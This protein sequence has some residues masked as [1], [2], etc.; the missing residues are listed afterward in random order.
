MSTLRTSIAIVC[1]V[2]SIASVCGAQTVD[3]ER[4]N[5]LMA[6]AGIALAGEDHATAVELFRELLEYYPV[7]AG[8]NYNLGLTLHK[9]GE[10][11]EAIPYLE[12]AL[13][14]EPNHTKAMSALGMVYYYL[15]DYPGARKCFLMYLDH[16]PGDAIIY[17]YLARMDYE[18]MNYADSADYYLKA[19][20]YAP[21]DAGM[22]YALAVCYQKSG[23]MAVAAETFLQAAEAGYTSEIPAADPVYHWAYC[24][25]EIDDYQTI[26]AYAVTKATLPLVAKMVGMAHYQL[27]DYSQAITAYQ[28]ALSEGLFEVYPLLARAYTK[29]EDYSKAVDVYRQ[30]IKKDPTDI[31]LYSNLAYNLNKLKQWDEAISVC[32]SGLSHAQDDEGLLRYF[33][34]VS[35][36][37]SGD[38][39]GGKA[40]LSKFV[41]TA[42]QKRYPNQLEQ[43]RTIVEG[44]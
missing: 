34:G 16:A 30:A 9:L 41:A 42:S 6:E 29:S 35:L 36:I 1:V 43:A 15:I 28:Q 26:T 8:I 44:E 20:S 5:Q 32:Y 19:L 4:A 7:D 31:S 12:K 24:L 39:E 37:N 27:G 10:N 11:R 25:Y 3:V 13:E 22:L 33:L 2:L 18:D 40:E 17:G 38:R 14:M 21:G 23:K